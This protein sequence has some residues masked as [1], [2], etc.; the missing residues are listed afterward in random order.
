LI[1]HIGENINDSIYLIEKNKEF[2]EFYERNIHHSFKFTSLN[3]D[4]DEKSIRR[5]LEEL[6]K[7]KNMTGFLLPLQ[8]RF[9]R[10][11]LSFKKAAELTYD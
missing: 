5:N 6:V 11:L 9:Q 10:L 2:N 4:S 3:L 1:L 8:R 7:N